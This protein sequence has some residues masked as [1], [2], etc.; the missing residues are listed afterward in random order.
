MYEGNSIDAVEVDLLPCRDPSYNPDS[1]IG[2][3]FYGP[4][5]FTLADNLGP[6]AYYTASSPM[7]M[8]YYFEERWMLTETNV[9]DATS[10]EASRDFSA[11]HGSVQFTH[12]GT[13][14]FHLES[15]QLVTVEAFTLEGN[16]VEQISFRKFYRTGTHILA[17]S[18]KTLR[19]NIFI[20]RISG[21]DFSAAG[22]ILLP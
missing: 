8:D 3:S 2:P 20:V 11:Y 5:Y 18:D 15:N 7:L 13:L 22:K 9:D 19:D 17:F 1:L 12:R 10:I 6:V 21:E 4:Q 16:K 14:S